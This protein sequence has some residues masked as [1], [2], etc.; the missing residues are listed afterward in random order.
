MLDHDSN[1]VILTPRK[2]KAAR[3][4]PGGGHI[5]GVAPNPEGPM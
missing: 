4:R 5:A 1:I 3:R 2:T